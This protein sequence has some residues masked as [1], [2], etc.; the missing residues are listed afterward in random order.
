MRWQ[1]PSTAVLGN[2]SANLDVVG[3]LAA[4]AEH[5]RPVESGDLASAHPC[6]AAQQYNEFIACWNFR[7]G[8]EPE[9]TAYIAF[10]QHL[11]RL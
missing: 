3:Y 9:Q 7:L 5:H 10:G 2:L 1:P 8:S 6:L 4:R 11:S